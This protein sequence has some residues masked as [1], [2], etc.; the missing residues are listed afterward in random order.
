MID[1]IDILCQEK[2]WQEAQC[3]DILQV[4]PHQPQILWCLAWV[5]AGVGMP[6]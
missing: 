1:Q 4:Q 2:H 3:L 5:A 6:D